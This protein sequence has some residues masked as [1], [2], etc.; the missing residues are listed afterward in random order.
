MQIMS[1]PITTSAVQEFFVRHL[2]DVFSTMLSMPVVPLAKPAPDDAKERVS[3]SVGFVGETVTG[4]VYLHLPSSFAAEITRA[5]LGLPAKETPADADVNDVLGEVTNMLA[6]GL[7]SWLCD[8]DA[9][10]ALGTP[11][12]IRGTSFHI[13]ACE[14]VAR[15]QLGFASSSHQ[16]LVEIHIKFSN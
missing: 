15:I 7:K 1:Q 6:G 8:A 4:S 5:M 14:G 12:I 3:G 13:S 16:G 11:A 2:A 10:C 9:A